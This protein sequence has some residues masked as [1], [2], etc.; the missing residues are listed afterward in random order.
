VTLFLGASWEDADSVALYWGDEPTAPLRLRGGRV[1]PLFP[2]TAD[3][4]A[5][6]PESGCVALLFPKSIRKTFAALIGA[7][8]DGPGFQ[9]FM[10]HG[11]ASVVLLTTS[12]ADELRIAIEKLDLELAA[13]EIWPF[14][15]GL[16][17]F[18]DVTIW[19][20]ANHFPTPSRRLDIAELPGPIAV[21]FRQFNANLALLDNTAREFAPEF[22]SVCDWLE[23]SGARGLSRIRSELSLQ[24]ESLDVAKRLHNDVSI[25]VDVNSCLSMVN[26][27]LA[28][29]QPPTLNSS[30]PVG[31]HSLLGIGSVSR[32]AFRLYDHI[33]DVF[34]AA[35]HPNRLR[36]NFPQVGF[37]PAFYPKHFDYTSW[38]LARNTRL[39]E[40]CENDAQ[41][42]RK[43]LV[44]FSSRW[45]FHE[46]LN[47]ISLSWQ[48]IG[49]GASREWNL[50]T[51]SHE[52]LHSHFR[53]LIRANVL[54]FTT[55]DQRDGLVALYNQEW[56]RPSGR[57]SFLDSARI[58]LVNQLKW[59]GEAE[60]A[61][62]AQAE[63]R[64][65]VDRESDPLDSEELIGLLAAPLLDFVEEVMVHIMDYHYF[66]NANDSAY[67]S[68]LWHSWT[69]VPQVHRR[70]RHYLLRTLF[71][72]ASSEQTTDPERAF[73]NCVM[74]LR[75]EFGDLRDSHDGP[76]VVAAIQDLED[77][78]ALRE[79][80]IRFQYNYQLV[81]FTRM[82]LID[83]SLY[84]GLNADS[85][86]T[87][88]EAP[89]YGI[90]PGDFPDWA[91]ESPSG[92]LL[93]RFIAGSDT[94][95]G[96]EAESLWQLLVLV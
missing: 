95:T 27:Q 40:R 80:F 63:G 85:Q 3:A 83:S 61:A 19:R 12:S 9:V 82:F 90:L 49:S 20:G 55:D 59:V 71:A 66:Y 53:E 6:L 14:S 45:G 31:E 21:E 93:D 60:L 47:S 29:V 44:Y 41:P 24:G 15:N 67:V 62:R 36:E 1:S 22:S 43:H 87:I 57:L 58:F 68:S 13:Y 4:P 7:C 48:T 86:A 54:D 72:L 78:H 73:E 74:R 50:L 37:D 94:L 11:L 26:S 77:G 16:L 17:N 38:E 69:L 42:G 34:A 81:V 91:I 88:G 30:F 39:A 8:S 2:L 32:A 84:S 89:R 52:F 46:T 33:S 64:S 76:L 51:L 96:T 56:E 92:F 79:L 35:D 23:E 28:D 18:R 70:L 5:A 75:R 65:V 10:S 25:L